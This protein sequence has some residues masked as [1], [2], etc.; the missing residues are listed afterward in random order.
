MLVIAGIAALVNVL[1][2]VLLFYVYPKY[3]KLPLVPVNQESDVS[4][5]L[6]DGTEDTPDTESAVL[7]SKDDVDDTKPS[8]PEAESQE[9]EVER[10]WHKPSKRL[11]LYA[12][13]MLVINIFIAAVLPLFYGNNEPLQV[14]STICALSLLWP[15]ALIDYTVYRIPNHFI[16]AGLACAVLAALMNL[17]GNTPELLSS[18]L[19]TLIMATVIAGAMLLI[20]LVLKGTGFGDVKLLFVIGLLL[21]AQRIWGALLLSLIV[22]FFV[23]VFLLARKKKG[24]QDL[25]P[26]A[27]FVA[28]GTYVSTV[29]MG[30]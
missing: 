9:Q 17:I 23:A 4:D 7:A 10:V 11:A 27:P 15:V 26:F 3:K 24:K 1:S 29:L 22:A 28:I 20:S 12:A 18:L 13:V 19:M 6:V 14:F 21:G 8:V 5:S 25:M 30:F 2:A 16:I